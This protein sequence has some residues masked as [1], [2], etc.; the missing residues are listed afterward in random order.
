MREI[1][2]LPPWYRLCERRKRFVVMQSWIVGITVL[3]LGIWMLIAHRNVQRSEYAL[4]SLQKQLNQ[5]RV[6]QQSLADQLTLRKQLQ[7]QKELLA[8]LGYPVE[9]T[10]LLHT[11]D[12]LMPK[13]MS[14]EEFNC[15]T[16]ERLRQEMSV[17]AVRG[18]VDKAKQFDRVLRVRLTGVSPSDQDLA[19]FMAGLFG[20]PFLDEV[21]LKSSKDIFERGHV[22]REFT[23]TFSMSLNQ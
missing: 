8:S 20:V 22:L 9:M 18:P 10:R 1:E 12:S 16:D 2:F 7:T 17:A 14:I 13:E 15:T 19:N 4:G 6:E 3:G 11:L 5:T 21:S 23:V